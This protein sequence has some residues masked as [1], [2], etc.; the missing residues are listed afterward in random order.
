LSE[1]QNPNTASAVAQ[2]PR[3]PQP[4]HERSLSLHRAALAVQAHRCRVSR[5]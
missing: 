1:A 5:R 4:A 2:Q 3:E